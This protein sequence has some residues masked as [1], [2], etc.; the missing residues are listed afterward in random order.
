MW[1]AGHI[2]RQPQTWLDVEVIG[3]SRP[4]VRS[5]RAAARMV[6]GQVQSVYEINDQFEI[7][8]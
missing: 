8:C 2:E 1:A 4:S 6:R 5:D 7:D 3:P